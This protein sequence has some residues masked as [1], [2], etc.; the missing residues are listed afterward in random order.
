MARRWLLFIW[1]FNGPIKQFC[2][3]QIVERQS[4]NKDRHN[5]VLFLNFWPLSTTSCSS[6]TH[7]RLSTC[8]SLLLADVSAV[9]SYDDEELNVKKKKKKTSNK[10]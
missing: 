9:S 2:W 4:P 8:P 7:F 1:L 10:H 5:S 6:S 3:S